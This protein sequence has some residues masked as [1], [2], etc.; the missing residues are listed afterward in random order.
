M[1]PKAELADPIVEDGAMAKIEEDVYE[2]A[3]RSGLHTPEKLEWMRRVGI[4]PSTGV[5]VDRGPP[6]KQRPRW[7]AFLLRLLL[8]P[9]D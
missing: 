1:I 7:L 3:A 8:G 2:R 4:I 6:V 5:W 9:G